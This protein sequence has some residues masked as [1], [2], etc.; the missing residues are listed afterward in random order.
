MGDV[1]LPNS[2]DVVPPAATRVLLGVLAEHQ[3]S[4]RAASRSVAER[5]GRSNMA[6]WAQ[7]ECLR[8]LGLIAWDAGRRGTLRPLVK[9][10][11]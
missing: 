3:A 9:V 5:I 1:R 11:R 2:P 6:T 7:F 4:G 8:G 10:V